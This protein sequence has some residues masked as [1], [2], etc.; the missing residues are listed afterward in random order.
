MEFP[1]YRQLFFALKKLFCQYFRHCRGRARRNF[2]GLSLTFQ[3]HPFGRGFH[4]TL[5]VIVTT[6]AIHLT[7]R[8]IKYAVLQNG[9]KV[10][11]SN[12]TFTVIHIVQHQSEFLCGIGISSVGCFQIPISEL[13]RKLPTAKI[14]LMIA[15]PFSSLRF[16]IS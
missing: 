4:T 1:F 2:T 16:I 13:C 3:S 11:R 14:R 7:V 8:Q 12:F 15:L 6:S 9:I 10:H 5:Q